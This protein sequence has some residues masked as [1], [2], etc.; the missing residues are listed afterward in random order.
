MYKV[1]IVDDEDMI[2]EGLRRYVDWENFGFVVAGEASDGNQAYELIAQL[3]PHVVL[4]DIRM[5]FCTGIQLMHRIRDEHIKTKV[6]V[7]SGYDEF[8]YARSAIETG[9]SGYLLKPIKKDKLREIFNRIRQE[10]DADIQTAIR[11]K[12]AG[13]LLR[14]EYL[15]RLVNGK[16]DTPEVLI[17]RGMQIGV[18]L[19]TEQF[20]VL[21]IAF[22]HH[23]RLLLKYTDRDLELLRFALRNVAEEMFTRW[24]GSYCYDMDRY[25]VGIL[26]AGRDFGSSELGMTAEELRR[27]IA[28]I[29]Q[30]DITISVGDI[31]PAVDD[32][33]ASHRSAARLMEMK[34]WV[35]T[36]R[37]ITAED[38]VLPPSCNAQS[39]VEWNAE[40]M[41]L[42]LQ[43]K[44]KRCVD[45]QLDACFTGLATKEAVYDAAY[46]LLKYA[47]KHAEKH[48]L[49]IP[50][51]AELKMKEMSL[52]QR[53]ETKDEIIATIKHIYA[54]L[55]EH[56]DRSGRNR[57]VDEVKKYI[58]A[59][60][61]ND[62]TL[63]SSAERIYVHPLHLSRIF[64][65]ETGI[66]FSD[67]L[68]GVRIA[69]SKQLLDDLSYKIY[70]ISGQVGYRD[71]RHFSKVFKNEVGITPTQYRQ[72]VLGFIDEGE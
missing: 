58:E 44:D 64:K 67:Y 46:R 13:R 21:L 62:I 45:E 15:R 59:D 43:K 4:T 2:R 11:N 31:V 66:T 23:S 51:L 16:S 54:G 47:L 19:Q 29:L 55:V 49:L 50:E 18:E 10:Y 41:A 35:G 22:D 61:A 30:C 24:G 6:V 56:A 38:S 52:L 32:I 57:L 34:F 68:T 37:L 17:G 70:E 71:A 9:A 65:K 8:E 63:E 69:R 33:P 53:K 7:L 27:T 36:S 12:E 3:Q 25:T 39:P 5:P 60:Y 40:K 14:E 26:I 42:L 48:T 1:I 28:R 20:C 72:L